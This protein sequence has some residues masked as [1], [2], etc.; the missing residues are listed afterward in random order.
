MVEVKHLPVLMREVIEYLKPER[1]GV[2][3]DATA[4]LGGHSKEILERLA[5]Q[6][7]LIALDRDEE[8][9]KV[10]GAQLK[11]TGKTNFVLKKA[12]FSEMGPALHEVREENKDL[13]VKGADGIL[14]DLGV[15]MLQLKGAG[16][17]FSFMADEPLDM[18]MDQSESLTAEKIINEYPEAELARIFW[19]Y[20]E[21]R[22][23][24]KIAKEI[25]TR[26]PKQ[27]IK[28]TGELADIARKFQRGRW[29]T[30]PATRIF[31]ALRIAVNNEMG[32]LSEALSS[33]PRVLNP[34]GR[35][36]VISYH[37]LEDRTVKRFMREKE[38]EGILKILTK[39]PVVPERE[40][41]RANPSARSAKLRAAERTI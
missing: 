16:R 2:F 15:S 6:G 40:E 14:F 30:H 5:G 37:S 17:G 38:R 24:R 27:K 26:R 12:R 41:T 3:I 4:G 29:K 28:T 20:G 1:G 10:A 34:A 11:A 35:L 39:K 31:Q 36:V 19:E 22:N 33:S 25:V 18:R 9:L 13:N 32:E 23:S 8:A 7:L 21:E